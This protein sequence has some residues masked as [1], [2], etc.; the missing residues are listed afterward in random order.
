MRGPSDAVLWSESLWRSRPHILYSAGMP[1]PGIPETNARPRRPRALFCAKYIFIVF[2]SHETRRWCASPHVHLQIGKKLACAN[3]FCIIFK[4]ALTNHIC[5]EHNT[6]IRRWK[7]IRIISKRTDSFCLAGALCFASRKQVATADQEK[8][9][10]EL[11]GNEKN[12]A[13][14]QWDLFGLRG[15]EPC[16]FSVLSGGILHESGRLV[17]DPLCYVN[18]CI[19][20]CFIFATKSKK[21]PIDIG[22]P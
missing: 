15:D 7:P 10:A 18:K 11:F 2:P 19:S 1:G 3:F 12:P 21:R 4:F 20:E 5:P 16:R 14:L 9:Y 6:K 13:A 17:V 22:L 8:W